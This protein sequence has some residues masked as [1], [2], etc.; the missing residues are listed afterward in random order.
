[1]VTV[2]S[3]HSAEATADRLESVLLEKNMKVFS[4]IDHAAGAASA[5]EALRPTILIIFGNPKVGTALLKCGQT[6]GIDLPLKAL[7]W[8]DEKGQVKFTY[9]DPNFIADRHGITNCGPVL[10]KMKGALK[11]FGEKATGE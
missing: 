1:M 8:E 9:N 11:A 6:A 10:E 2:E 4:R 5:G 7:I 3:S